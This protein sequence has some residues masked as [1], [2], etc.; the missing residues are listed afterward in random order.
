M[1]FIDT[2]YS[3]YDTEKLVFFFFFYVRTA[4]GRFYRVR[5][6]VENIYINTKNIA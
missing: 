5:C 4:R 2:L 3:L 1:Y 6:Y